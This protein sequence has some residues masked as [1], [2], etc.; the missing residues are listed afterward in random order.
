MVAAR[1]FLT[2]QDP[3]GGRE[4][5]LRRRVLVGRRSARRP[6]PEHADTLLPGSGVQS[7]GRYGERR[8]LLSPDAEPPAGPA[9]DQRPGR[10]LASMT[11]GE[12]V[13]TGAVMRQEW[14]SN[15]VKLS[16][17][18]IS[19]NRLRQ[20]Q[21]C[22]DCAIAVKPD[23]RWCPSRQPAGAPQLMG[24][25]FQVGTAFACRGRHQLCNRG[26]AGPIPARVW[27][28]RLYGRMRSR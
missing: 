3:P 12:Q 10:C 25:A 20:A 15:S 7:A 17:F 11:A 5:R 18:Y 9:A 24:R 4:G 22:I 2:R 6:C 14:A 16:A 19:S 21:Y 23:G 13:L 1:G 28:S 8:V 26:T 27:A